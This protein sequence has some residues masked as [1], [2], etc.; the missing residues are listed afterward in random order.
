M[1][2]PTPLAIFIVL[3]PLLLLSDLLPPSAPE[4]FG[5]LGSG[6]GLLALSTS[7]ARSMDCCL[8]PMPTLGPEGCT[9]LGPEPLSELSSPLG[10]SIIPSS[11]YPCTPS[12]ST[13]A[14]LGVL[15]DFL[16]VEN[17]PLT[18]PLAPLPLLGPP[19]ALSLF[20]SSMSALLISCISLCVSPKWTEAQTSMRIEDMKTI[21]TPTQLTLTLAT[22]SSARSA[23][24]VTASSAHTHVLSP[25]RKS[26]RERSMQ[27]LGQTKTVPLVV[28]LVVPLMRL[29]SVPLMG[30]G[31]GGARGSESWRPD[32]SFTSA[33]FVALV[34][35]RIA[36]APT[37]AALLTPNMETSHSTSAMTSRMSSSM[38]SHHRKMMI[39][40]LSAQQVVAPS[41]VPLWSS[42]MRIIPK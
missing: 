21:T 14:M 39:P 29:K 1:F 27:L 30:G 15:L 16:P 13:P 24:C 6:G 18:Q 28:P 38:K 20:L 41:A 32:D 2:L 9:K 5:A 19:L 22:A 35:L 4:F 12:S 34:A 37:S 8:G 31:A 10:F 26:K 23:A 33:L 36:L 42:L 17:M 11:S 7:M 25:S 3:L 40:E